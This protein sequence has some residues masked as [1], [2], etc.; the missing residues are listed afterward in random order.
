MLA[1]AIIPLSVY[2]YWTGLAAGGGTIKKA[3]NKK[4]IWFSVFFREAEEEKICRHVVS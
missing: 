3:D 2:P 4:M 1:K